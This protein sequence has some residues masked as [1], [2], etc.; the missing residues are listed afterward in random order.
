MMIE[1][2]NPCSLC[3]L[4]TPLAPYPFFLSVLSYTHEPT[5]PTPPP[6]HTHTQM[7]ERDLSSILNFLVIE[8]QGKS[9]PH[10]QSIF[11]TCAKHLCCRVLHEIVGTGLF[12]QPHS[13]MLVTACFMENLFFN[14]EY[15]IDSSVFIAMLAKKQ[16]FLQLVVSGGVTV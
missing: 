9:L 16:I 6:P 10:V 8:I 1:W 5:Y 4:I 11:T 3:L 12:T 7:G 15:Y 13:V 2:E 14:Q